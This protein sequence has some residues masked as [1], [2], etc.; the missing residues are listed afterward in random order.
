MSF[1]MMSFAKQD[2]KF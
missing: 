1:E 2:K